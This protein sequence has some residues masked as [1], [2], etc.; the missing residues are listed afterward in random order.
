MLIR[1]RV[2]GFLNKVYRSKSLIWCRDLV[3]PRHN[4][5]LIILDGPRGKRLIAGKNIVTAAGNIWYAQKVGGG[6]LT[7]NFN[8][9]YLS[10]V[11]FSPSPNTNTDSSD[12]SGV[13]SLSKKVIVA[14]YPTSNDTDTD[15]DG[16]G[17]AVV[18]HGFSWLRTDFNATGIQG[19]TIAETGTAWGGSES[20]PLLSARNEDA[21]GFDKGETDT[22]KVFINHT[23]LGV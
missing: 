13:I 15:N 4:N 18:S 21:P 5:V 11:A 20:G 9:M 3:V 19:V 8:Y 6:S 7:N 17:T 2:T 14:P 16:R 12:L 10:Q 23:L 22:L 1:S